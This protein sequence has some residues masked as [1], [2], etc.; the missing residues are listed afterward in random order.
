MSKTAERRRVAVTLAPELSA[1]YVH[2][3]YFV[4]LREVTA[5]VACLA[6]LRAA[7]RLSGRLR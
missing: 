7:P 3:D 2:A 1:P 5:N 4:P 6:R